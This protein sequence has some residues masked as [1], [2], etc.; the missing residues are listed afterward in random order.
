MKIDIKQLVEQLVIDKALME[1][2][3]KKLQDEKKELIDKIN[4]L[5]IENK[6]NQQYADC[7]VIK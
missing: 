7:E 5:K 4:K 3:I 6:E 2:E 1:Q